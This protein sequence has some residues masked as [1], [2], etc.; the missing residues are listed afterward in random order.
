MNQNLNPM[1]I[2]RNFSQKPKTDPSLFPSMME[3]KLLI[4]MSGKVIRNQVLKAPMMVISFKRY[5]IVSWSLK[6][7]RRPKTTKKKNGKEKKDVKKEKRKIVGKCEKK[8]R[9]MGK[10]NGKLLKEA[11]QFQVYLLSANLNLIKIIFVCFNRKNLKC[12][13]KMPKLIW[14]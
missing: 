10:G 6:L 2:P 14:I 12:S 7:A 9:K 13:R 4:L 11:L 8:M 1:M 3:T 5:V